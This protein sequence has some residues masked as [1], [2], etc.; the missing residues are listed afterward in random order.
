MPGTIPRNLHDIILYNF[1]NYHPS[2]CYYFTHFI[3][4]AAETWRCKS[5]CWQTGELGFESRR[6]PLPLP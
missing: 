4:E 3:D 6:N 5:P 1:L 2:R